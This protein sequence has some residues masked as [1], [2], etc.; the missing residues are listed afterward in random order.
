MKKIIFIAI[1]LLFG[2]QI[3][4]TAQDS[5]AILD[6]LNRLD[7]KSTYLKDFKFEIEPNS[8]VK[9]SILLSKGTYYEFA[10]YQ[11]HAKQF[12]FELYKDKSE[13]NLVTEKNE[14]PDQ[15]LKTNYFNKHT[16]V[17][18]LVI[19]NKSNTL[20]KS[21]L[22]LSFFEKDDAINNEEIVTI[23]KNNNNEQ[24]SNPNQINDEIFVVV[25]QMPIFGGQKSQAESTDMFRDFIAKN[26]IYPEEAKLK[27]IKGRVYV[28][29]VVD[30]E[31]YIKTAKVVRSVHPSLDQEALR[32]VFTSPRWEPGKQR[33][34]AVN[35][36]YTFPIFF[37][38][39][40]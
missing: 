4:L 23:E 34:Q 18:H 37:F 6:K 8:N 35:V 27:Q 11:N 5:E 40:E 3:N 15:I 33:G 16:G 17:Y 20:A 2:F 29:F 10:I 36:S 25:E 31:G 14:F 30:K 24:N 19:R 9:Y 22:L 1:T 38:L 39:T 13:T 12:D 26:I 28:S 7:E 21:V 32:V